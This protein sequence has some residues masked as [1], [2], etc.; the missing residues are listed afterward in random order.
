MCLYCRWHCTDYVIWQYY[1]T[2]YIRAKR[3]KPVNLIYIH[4]MAI[5]YRKGKY[6]FVVCCNYCRSVLMCYFTIKI[7]GKIMGLLADYTVKH[8]VTTRATLLFLLRCRGNVAVNKLWV[9]VCSV[10]KQCEKGCQVKQYLQFTP[11]PNSTKSIPHVL[12]VLLY[13]MWVFPYFQGW[14]HINCTLYTVK[15][16]QNQYRRCF[17]VFFLSNLIKIHV[18]RAICDSANMLKLF[19]FFIITSHRCWLLCFDTE[20]SLIPTNL[21]LSICLLTPFSSNSEQHTS[22]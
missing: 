11:C 8:T 12:Q 9:F 16:Y 3:F 17:F 5:N 14:V 18:T 7:N 2:R 20:M 10:C 13:S 6:I 21:K 1:C 22:N 19:L 15:V 4:N